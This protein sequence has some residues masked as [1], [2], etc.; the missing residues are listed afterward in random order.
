MF[1]EI[2]CYFNEGETIDYEALGLEPNPDETVINLAMINTDNI[3]VINPSSNQE[4]S[5]IQFVSGDRW[6]FAIKYND[7]KSL[8]SK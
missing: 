7:L 3:E 1:I 5:T 6:L 4:D 8:I 2:P